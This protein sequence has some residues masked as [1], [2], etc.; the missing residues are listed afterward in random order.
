VTA[1]NLRTALGTVLTVATEAGTGNN[2]VANIFYFRA[3]QIAF[4]ETPAIIITS[5]DDDEQFTTLGASTTEQTLKI[6]IDYL[7]APLQGDDL[8]VQMA[9]VEAWFEQAK[10]NLR[11]N[12]KGTISNANSW[13]WISRMRTII[14]QP[15]IDEGRVLYH[16][17][18]MVWLKANHTGS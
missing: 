12:P 1:L 13:S 9:A 4:D 7:D 11:R 3:D 10:T 8:Q 16:G 18:L 6:D 5:P 14:D 2:P 15:L 17:T